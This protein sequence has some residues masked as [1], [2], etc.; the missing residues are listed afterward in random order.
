MPWIQGQPPQQRCSVL[1]SRQEEFS[2]SLAICIQAR[3]WSLLNAQRTFLALFSYIYKYIYICVCVCV[4]LNVPSWLCFRVYIYVRVC[5]CVCVPIYT[6][7]VAICR[8]VGSENYHGAD[9]AVGLERA[10]QAER[11]RFHSEL[12]VVS[13][14]S[15]ST[16]MLPLLTTT[17]DLKHN[18][19]VCRDDYRSLIRAETDVWLARS[20][21]ELETRFYHTAPVRAAT[22]ELSF[23]LQRLLNT[24]DDHVWAS[25]V[26]TLF[27]SDMIGLGFGV[28][29]R[30]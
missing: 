28:R 3:G 29:V 8:H 22:Q 6:R 30:G 11:A 14:T 7:V 23:D 5:V 17:T 26:R 9:I 27:I 12:A 21:S 13:A 15:S 4:T 2:L 18:N 20:R 16:E 19:K 10:L 25:F 1:Q 24:Y